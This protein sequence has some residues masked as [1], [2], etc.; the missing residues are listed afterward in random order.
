MTFLKK[1]R[2]QPKRSTSFLRLV[3]STA[4]TLPL[5][6]GYNIQAAQAEISVGVSGRGGLSIGRGSDIEAGVNVGGVSAG[7]SVGRESGAN[8]GARVGGQDGV[9]AGVSAKGDSVA[10]AGVNVG[11]RD[12]ISAGATVGGKS[13][14]SAG[15]NIGGSG[16]KT[17]GVSV[18]G[19][20]TGGNG[21]AVAGGGTGKNSGNGKNVGT[22]SK[23]ASV[24]SDGKG[25][26]RGKTSSRDVATAKPRTKLVTTLSTVSTPVMPIKTKMRCAKGGNSQVYNGLPVADQTGTVVGWVHDVKLDQQLNVTDLRLQTVGKRCVSLTGGTYKVSEGMIRVKIDAARLQ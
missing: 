11:G 16:G 19:D 23:G 12:G 25:A 3:L 20:N 24:G 22:G 15:A 5:A 13:V 14:A 1:M 26:G 9:S 10:K 7:A 17:G 4:V 8:V 21:G 6:L 18:G 2:T